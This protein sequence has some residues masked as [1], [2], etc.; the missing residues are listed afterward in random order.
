MD[1]VTFIIGVAIAGVVI[2]FFFIWYKKDQKNV[3]E[4]LSAM[5]EETLTRVREAEILSVEGKPNCWIQEAVIGRAVDK[6]NSVAVRTLYMNKTIT[7]NTYNTICHADFKIDKAT[8]ESRG[9]KE[10]SFIQMYVD[11]EKGASLAK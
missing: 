8:Y 10:G 5:S 9:L 11:P 1:F 7:N 6:G 4:M 3:S 2:A